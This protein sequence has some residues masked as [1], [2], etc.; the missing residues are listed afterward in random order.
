MHEHDGALDAEDSIGDGD[1][2]KGKDSGGEHNT[3][4]DV[5]NSIGDTALSVE[6]SNVDNEHN[7]L[8]DKVDVGGKPNNT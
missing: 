2:V 4:M 8:F 5:R 3:N 1:V 6:N 7:Y